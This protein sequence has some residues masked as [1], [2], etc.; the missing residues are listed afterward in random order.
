MGLRPSAVFSLGAVTAIALNRAQNQ[1][2]TP[3]AG[4]PA[5]QEQTP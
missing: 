4:D 1:A 3:L 5:G 2:D